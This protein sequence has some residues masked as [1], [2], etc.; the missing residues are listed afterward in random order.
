M[1][2]VSQKIIVA[3]NANGLLNHQEKLQVFVI[4]QN[5]DISLISET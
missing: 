1:L 4:E 5:T 2:F 3:W